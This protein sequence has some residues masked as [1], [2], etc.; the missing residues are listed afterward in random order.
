M[1]IKR[2]DP[3]VV[4][5]RL[6]LY[7][8]LIYRLFFWLHFHI[9]PLV[10]RHNLPLHH[11]HTQMKWL[12]TMKFQAKQEN[13]SSEKTKS[14]F[15]QFNI[16]LPVKLVIVQ[17]HS[18][19]HIL[20]E[21]ICSDTI[22]I[23]IVSSYFGYFFLSHFFPSIFSSAMNRCYSFHVRCTYGVYLWSIHLRQLFENCRALVKPKL[24]VNNCMKFYVK[25]IQI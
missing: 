25:S 19:K 9:I 5:C 22:Q 8:S 6:S 17:S 12:C 23:R 15:N 18:R 3:R 1:Q 2:I 14:K 20:P 16:T 11:T 13:K 4:F 10:H 24:P 7:I 21:S